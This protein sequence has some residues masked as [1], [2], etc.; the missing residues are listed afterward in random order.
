MRLRIIIFRCDVV[1]YTGTCTF[2]CPLLFTPL[3]SLTPRFRAKLATV[4]SLFNFFYG[5]F[6]LEG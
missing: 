6:A 4:F 5:K 2:L 3:V 1:Y